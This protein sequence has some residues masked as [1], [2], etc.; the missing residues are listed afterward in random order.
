[1]R[2]LRFMMLVAVLGLAWSAS[3]AWAMGPDQKMGMTLRSHVEVGESPAILLKPVASMEAL[4]IRVTR[5]SDNKDF[6]FKV[7]ALNKGKS[8]VLA[9]KQKAGTQRYRAHVDVKFKGASATAFAYEFEATVT[10]P[11]A[12]ELRKR[13]VDLDGHSLSVKS[14]R[15]TARVDLR[16]FG[17]GRTLVG[18]GSQTFDA[19]PAGRGMQVAWKQEPA[20]VR[21]IEV[22]V[23]DVNGFWAAMEIRPFFVEPWEDRIYFATGSDHVESSEEPKLEATLARIRKAIQMA[24]VEYGDTIDMRLYVAGYTDTVGSAAANR[25][26]SHRRARSIGRHLIGRGLKIP[27]FHQGFGEDVLAVSTPDNTAHESNR[28]T[29]YV[30]SSQVPVSGAFPRSQWKRL[31]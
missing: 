8:K 26:L 1:M 28:R 9:F 15:R 7:G 6:S 2:R 19:A 17:E 20:N 23:T 29:L 25:E 21:V 14:T 27:V 16:V 3:I 4:S 13:D 31:R 24:Q 5:L 11:L 12:I 10:P 30:L 18:E 22:K